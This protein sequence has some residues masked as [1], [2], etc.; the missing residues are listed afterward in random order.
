MDLPLCYNTS[1]DDSVHNHHFR[2]VILTLMHSNS[3]VP[4]VERYYDVLFVHV[5]LSWST[6]PVFRYVLLLWCYPCRE[7]WS[8][9]YCIVVTLVLHSW[10]PWTLLYLYGADYDDMMIPTITTDHGL[11]L[12]SSSTMPMISGRRRRDVSSS[13]LL[14]ML[15]SFVVPPGGVPVAEVMICCV[16]APVQ[17]LADEHLLCRWWISLVSSPWWPLELD[18]LL[19]SDKWTL[20]DDDEID[21]SSLP[22]LTW[23]NFVYCNDYCIIVSEHPVCLSVCHPTLCRVADVCI[24]SAFNPHLSCI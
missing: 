2:T 12:P 24:Y 4:Y 5:L 13:M 8:T 10:S 21:D 16:R 3:G 19:V 11:R 1:Y 23:L 14:T 18:K 20:E 7:S 15:T 6:V 9:R 22:D 17:L